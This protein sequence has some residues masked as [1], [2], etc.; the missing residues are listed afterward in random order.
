VGC[1]TN[2]RNNPAEATTNSKSTPEATAVSGTDKSSSIE[3]KGNLL[4]IQSDTAAKFIESF[5]YKVMINSGVAVGIKL[6]GDFNYKKDSIEIGKLLYERNQLSK[7]YSL[8]FSD[9]MGKKIYLLEYKMLYNDIS[10]GYMVMLFDNEKMV[11]AWVDESNE[12][13][14][15]ILMKNLEQYFY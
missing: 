1:S 15:N 9:Y 12:Q 8:D 11:G 4:Q 5:G 2:S 10:K 13:D 6:P 14:M 7:K 3:N